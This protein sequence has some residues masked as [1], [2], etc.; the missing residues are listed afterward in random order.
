MRGSN[1]LDEAQLTLPLPEDESVNDN[2]GSALL[3]MGLPLLKAHTIAWIF[4][5]AVGFLARVVLYNDVLLAAEMTLTL[6]P[7][8][9]LMTAGFHM[10]AVR[11]GVVKISPRF[12]LFGL[13]FCVLAAGVQMMIGGGILVS[14]EKTLPWRDGGV[15]AIP[16]TYYFAIFV[17]WFS[18]YAWMISWS[19]ARAAETSRILAETNATRAELHRLRSQLDPHFLYN[20][21]N[22]IA[23]EIHHNPDGALE[24][25]RNTAAFLRHNLEEHQR[26]VCS[27]AEEIDSLRTYLRIQE[28]RFEVPF[29]MGVDVSPFAAQHL[30]PRWTL[31]LLVE[32]AF[33]HGNTSDLNLRVAADRDNKGLLLRVRNAGQ[34]IPGKADMGIGL[35]NLQR[36]LDLHFPN[37]HLFHLRQEGDDVVAELSLRGEPCFA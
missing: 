22:T 34:L 16:A 12:A 37:R 8:G 9:Y 1:L 17:C 28:G 4:L 11:I 31:Q 33:K 35:S 23:A 7:L 14:F 3:E 29:L 10:A 6:D 2:T 25:T 19:K 30:L 5:A 32:N 36:R 15:A 20:T 13:M 26:P 27:L 21:L 18:L 24:M